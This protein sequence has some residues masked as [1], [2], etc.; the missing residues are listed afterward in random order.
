M[1]KVFGVLLIGL[2]SACASQTPQPSAEVEEKSVGAQPQ[3]EASR[4]TT[5]GRPDAQS[6]YGSEEYSFQT[7]HLF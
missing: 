3:G 6:A 7:Q 5:E 2:L 4:T 1:K